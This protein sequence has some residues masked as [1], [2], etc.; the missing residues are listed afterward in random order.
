MTATWLFTWW[1]SKAVTGLVTEQ[2]AFHFQHSIPSNSAS[3]YLEAG[4]T[5]DLWST[6]GTKGT[7]A[8]NIETAGFVF[9]GATSLVATS[10]SII[11]ASFLY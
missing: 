3:L 7:V 9:V 1:N 10:A 4:D 5:D 6:K 8:G 2:I 11:F